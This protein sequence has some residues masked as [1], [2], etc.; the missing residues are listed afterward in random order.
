MTE[1][2]TAFLDAYKEH[3]DAL[4]RYC[5]FRLKKPEAASDLVQDTYMKVWAYIAKGN[6]IDNL[7]A[8]LYRT[9]HN[10]V[11]D[12]YRKHVE[13]SLDVL[14]EAGFDPGFDDTDRWIDQLDGEQAM[15]LLAT[16]PEEYR[17]AVYMRYVDGLSNK[18]IAE[19]TGQLENTIAVRIKRGLAK[20]KEA[21][22]KK[23]A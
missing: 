21:Y 6:K 15:K 16:L 7:K 1:L 5:Y 14:A 11:V 19:A 9:A 22:P 10:L 13:E 4:Y 20:L 17:E 18:E 3:S 23:P 12:E 8:F 2:E